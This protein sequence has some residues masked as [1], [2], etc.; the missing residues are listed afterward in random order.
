M[1]LLTT[2]LI[3]LAAGYITLVALV[4]FH[5]ERLA[6]FPQPGLFESPEN[7]GYT[8]E[9]V[10]LDTADGV[11]IHGWYVPAAEPRGAAIFF[12]GNGNNIDSNAHELRALQLFGFN[13]LMLDYRGYGLSEGSPIEAGLYHDADAAWRYMT[14]T[15]GIAPKSI[16]L[17]G[18]S[19]GGGVA[20]YLAQQHDVAGVV[21]MAT[22]TSMADVGAEHY[23]F[24][25]VHLLS[26]NRYPSL[27][28]LPD[29][30]APLLIIHSRD[31]RT[32]G[33]SHAERLYAAANEPKTLIALDGYG[34]GVGLGTALIDHT[35]EVEH[36]FES[37]PLPAMQ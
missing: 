4:F 31:D 34:H 18:Q 36:F 28:R 10:W 9:D 11:R 26:R 8:Y 14:E 16:V 15:R 17:V 3:I 33:F 6:Y 27:A 7:W 24:L 21:L 12:H 35:P 23:S 22:F 37:L 32:I 29:I 5:Q 30:Q 19:L 2:S 1:F 25:P 20:T 13:T